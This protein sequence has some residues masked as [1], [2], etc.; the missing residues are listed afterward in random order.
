MTTSEQQPEPPLTDDRLREILLL[1]VQGRIRIFWKDNIREKLAYKHG[2]SD[3]DVYDL[4]ERWEVLK[5]VEFDGL[6]W[7]YCIEGRNSIGEWMRTSA[8][9]YTDPETIVVP[10]TCHRCI[11][12]KKK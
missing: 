8:A 7:R 5:T 2:L 1:V 10:I 9:I 11:R 6:A 3:K 12:S 4:Y